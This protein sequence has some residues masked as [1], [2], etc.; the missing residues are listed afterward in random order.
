M[1]EINFRAPQ[2]EWEDVED[3]DEEDRPVRRKKRRRVAPPKSFTNAQIRSMILGVIL[4]IVGAVVFALALPALS[5]RGGR[6][7]ARFVAYGVVIMIGGIVS[8]FFGFLGR[9]D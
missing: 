2:L 9:E 7:S 6:L 3:E 4:I 5:G 8:F 1:C